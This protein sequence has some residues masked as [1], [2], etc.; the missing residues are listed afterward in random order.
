MIY[1]AGTSS[2]VLYTRVII[3][4]IIYNYYQF[5]ET[6]IINVKTLGTLH[7]IHS[8]IP[9]RNHLGLLDVMMSNG[10]Y[11]CVQIH[12]DNLDKNEYEFVDITRT[13]KLKKITNKLIE[14]K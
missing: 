4:D 6:I 14:I 13:L 9:L 12:N 7:N 10:T 3:D 11:F 8:I 1:E 2:N 5:K